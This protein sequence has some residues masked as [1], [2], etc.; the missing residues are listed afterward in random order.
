VPAAAEYLP[1]THSTQL[2]SEVCAG[3]LEALPAG[4]FVHLGS[5]PAL[6]VPA[7]QTAQERVMV[8]GQGS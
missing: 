4:H 2:A 8:M 5:A 3:E 1:A 6:Y 7:T